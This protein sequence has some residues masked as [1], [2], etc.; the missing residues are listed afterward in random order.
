MTEKEFWEKRYTSGGN[1]G[2][3]STGDYRKWKW[4]I[5]E[6]FT[7]LEELAVLDVGCGDLSFIGDRLEEIGHY[8][9]IDISPHIIERHKKEH[10]DPWFRF[11]VGDASEIRLDE[12]FDVV[13]CFDV[14]FHIMSDVRFAAVL[15]NLN[16]WTGEWLFIV[17]WSKNPLLTKK[18]DG[19]FQYFRDLRRWL[20][21]LE[22]LELVAAHTHAD[23]F[24]TLYVFRRKEDEQ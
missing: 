12:T 8:T 22:G 24:N 15:R 1:S 20:D 16:K 9:G 14:L 17:T 2:Q 23:G 21:H 11:Y 7:C 13:F 6:R 4:D 10:L 19:V 3:G 18:H 5:I